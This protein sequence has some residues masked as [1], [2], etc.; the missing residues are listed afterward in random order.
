MGL[1]MD[2]WVRGGN[3]GERKGGGEEG[4]KTTSEWERREIRGKCLNN[5]VDG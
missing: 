5:T 4:K 1:R 3:R 2:E